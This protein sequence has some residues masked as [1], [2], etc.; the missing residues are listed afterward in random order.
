MFLCA[1]PCDESPEMCDAGEVCVLDE[2]GRAFCAPL[3][4]TRRRAPSFPQ[5]LLDVDNLIRYRTR[6]DRETSLRSHMQAST[7]PRRKCERVP[8]SLE[9]L[10][11]WKRERVRLRFGQLLLPHGV[12]FAST[13]VCDRETRFSRAKGTVQRI[14]RVSQ[15]VSVVRSY[16]CS[17]TSKSD[18]VFERL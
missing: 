9:V 16:R 6:C 4:G 8:M 11:S 5:R 14:G 12:S 13:F 3:E 10:R 18:G 1:D 17:S 7:R 15:R 2:E